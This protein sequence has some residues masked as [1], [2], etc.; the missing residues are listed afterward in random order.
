MRFLKEVR[1]QFAYED[2]KKASL[3]SEKVTTIAFKWGFTHLG[4]F[5]TDYKNR[6]GETPYETLSR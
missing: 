5:S 6:F 3:G 1:L 4:Y 2:L